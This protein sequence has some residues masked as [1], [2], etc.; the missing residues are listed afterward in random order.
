MPGAVASLT[1]SAAGIK[2]RSFSVNSIPSPGYQA[3]TFALISA[4][5][6]DAAT[7]ASQSAMYFI[8]HWDGAD[9]CPQPKWLR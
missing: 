4:A 9:I 2:W 5:F 1:A 6:F 3:S 7:L 8:V